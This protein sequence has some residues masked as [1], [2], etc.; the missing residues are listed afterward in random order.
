MRQK[1]EIAEQSLPRLARSK[2]KMQFTPPHPNLHH[3][4]L[5]LLSI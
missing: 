5:P 2:E 4:K 1:K 3:D